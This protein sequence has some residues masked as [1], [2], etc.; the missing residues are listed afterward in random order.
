[1]SSRGNRFLH[2]PS[3][4]H[5]RPVAIRPPAPTNPVF[6]NAFP[7]YESDSDSDRPRPYDVIF[8][9]SSTSPAASTSS[10]SP[11]ETPEIPIH[12]RVDMTP[13]VNDTESNNQPESNS[14]DISGI[15]DLHVTTNSPESQSHIFDE[16]NETILQEQ[17]ED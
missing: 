12:G 1:M 10:P 4:T 14:V 15:Q 11:Q 16:E 3:G 13:N 8:D 9:S 17:I 6:I 2:H 5:W 7:N